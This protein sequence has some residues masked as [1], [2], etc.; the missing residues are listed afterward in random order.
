MGAPMRFLHSALDGIFF[1]C[2]FY[3]ASM[4]M[5][6]KCP[7]CYKKEMQ[8]AGVY[9]AHGVRCDNVLGAQVLSCVERIGAFYDD[10]R[11]V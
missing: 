10:K 4:R 2:A 11:T 8:R 1:S 5:C 7:V 3:E 9:E 6:S